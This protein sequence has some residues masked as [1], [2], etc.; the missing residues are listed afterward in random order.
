MFCIAMLNSRLAYSLIIFLGSCAILIYGKTLLI[1]F[2]LALFVWFLI[3]EVRTGLQKFAPIRKLPFW[4][5]TILASGLMLGVLGAIVR[6]ISS[7]IQ[8]LSKSMSSYE[9]NVNK[10]THDLEELLN[11]NLQEEFNRLAVDFNF[12]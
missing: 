3:K 4:P 7:N 5:L 12:H 8:Q 2:V 1:P 6:V 11:L 9:G 10:I